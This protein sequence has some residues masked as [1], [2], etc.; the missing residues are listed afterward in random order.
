MRRRRSLLLLA[1]DTPA[2]D[3]V[4]CTGWA[5]VD[6]KDSKAMPE[7]LDRGA[8]SGGFNGFVAF[9]QTLRFRD[10]FRRVSRVVVEKYVPYG[11]AGDTSPLLAEGALMYQLIQAGVPLVRQPASGKNKMIPDSFLK[12]QGWY[13]TK[14]HHHDER[15]AVRHALYYLTKQRHKPLLKALAAN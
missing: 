7:V 14:G 4:S 3:P 12:T 5:V 15:E 13:T 1:I 6:D 2:E 8:I 10:W 9:L 11:G